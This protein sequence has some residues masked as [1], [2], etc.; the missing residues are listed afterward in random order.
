[1]T[2]P[3]LRAA[4]A[5][6]GCAATVT[7]AATRGS[8]PRDS[9]TTMVVWASGQSGTIGGGAL[10]FEAVARA[11]QA[12]ARGTDRIDRIALGPSLGQ[13]C[14]GAVTL[15]TEIW[16]AGRLGEAAGTET[17]VESPQLATL[18]RAIAAAPPIP[19]RPLWLWGAGHVGRAIAD[20]LA[21]TGLALT[22]L[23][24][25]ANL[26][27]SPPRRHFAHRHLTNVAAAAATAPADADH[28]ILTHAHALDLEICHQLLARPARS[29]GL[30]GSATKRARFRAR[31]TALGHVP[32]DLG[33]IRC[34]I[35]RPA[36]G[37]EPESIAVGV[38]AGLLLETP[39]LIRLGD[40]G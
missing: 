13:C 34:P 24:A 26:V 16:H 21:G 5:A 2:A 12:L 25:R 17:A 11:R 32:D 30:I 37:K 36:L 3:D 33:R 8:A 18:R 39:E 40:T 10:E 28:L 27:A 23:D 15:K 1:M 38:I 9:G 4:V 7:V 35:G 22:W 6:H 20:Q 31:L 14:G 19:A 29:I